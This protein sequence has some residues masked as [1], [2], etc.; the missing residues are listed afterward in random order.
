MIF[1]LRGV[2]QRD[3]RGRLR[4][5]THASVVLPDPADRKSDQSRELDPEDGDELTN[6]VQPEQ[7]GRIRSPPLL[8]RGF[9]LQ[10]SAGP[11]AAERVVELVVLRRRL[12]REPRQDLQAF[13]VCMHASGVLHRGRQGGRRDLG[14][15][16]RYLRPCVRCGGSARGACSRLVGV[17]SSRPCRSCVLRMLDYQWEGPKTGTIPWRCAAVTVGPWLS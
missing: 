12:L 17:P 14:C 5:N 6:T 4:W 11:R 1:E 2:R 8:K 16:G 3:L 7:R 13:V 9:I 15:I 10:P